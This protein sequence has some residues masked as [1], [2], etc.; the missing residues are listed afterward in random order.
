MS[1]ACPKCGAVLPSD[2][3]GLCAACVL[4]GGG[5]P[6][7]IGGVLEL[8]DE[9]GRGGMGTVYRAR[10]GRLGRT[11]AIKFLP[12]DLIDRDDVQVRFEREANALG[13]LNHP[14]VITLHDMAIE[15][16][17]TYIVMEYAEGGPVSRLG[18]VEPKR[19]AE[20]GK[21][22]CDGLQHAHNLGV[23]H[24]D[25]KPE[26][27]LLDGEGRV[28]LG[29]FGLARLVGDGAAGWT[30]TATD[31][32]VGTPHYIAPEAMR[33]ADPDP[34]M[35][36]YAVGV[37][38][39]ELTTGDLPMGDFDPAPPELDGIIRR[40]LAPDPAKRFPSAEEMADALDEV[41]ARLDKR[42]TRTTKKNVAGSADLPADE[43]SWVR[44]VAILQSISTAAAIWA[45]LECV[46]PKWMTPDQIPFLVVDAPV[47]GSETKT[48]T[49]ARFE[50]F[51][52]LVAMATFAV[53]ITSYG[54]LRRHWARNNLELFMPD[55][56]VRHSIRVLRPGRGRRDLGS[57]TLLFVGFN[58]DELAH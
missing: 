34:R 51:W 20:I 38:L 44:A 9:I 17:Q 27:V 58:P 31:Q 3:L 5:T 21:Q 46:T 7:M 30:V 43:M 6:V 28:K 40:A 25:I 33:G 35:D 50:T 54:A 29:D 48:L 1:D 23:V 22:I 56:S 15:D 32:V 12:D 4:T 41:I 10:H 37:L 14:N 57:R 42:H 19:A 49:L 24:R 55:Q 39:Y 2:R 16:G 11:V 53:A 8:Q 52:V 26:N 36:I 13:R 18:K 47:L 45:F